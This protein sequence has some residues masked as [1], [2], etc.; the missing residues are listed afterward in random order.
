MNTPVMN[1]PIV[2]K[3]KFVAKGHDAIL[4]N[5]QDA[6]SDI[7]IEFMSGNQILG[8]LVNRDKYTIT[9]LVPSGDKMT[10]YKH[11]IEF[12]TVVKGTR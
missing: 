3:P 6:G 2:N 10:V 8:K 1:T 7:A 9:V 11:A 12:F 5:A 4:K